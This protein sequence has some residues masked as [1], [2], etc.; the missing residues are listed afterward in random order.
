MSVT[1]AIDHKYSRREQS[2]PLTCR[3]VAQWMVEENIA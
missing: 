3:F 2:R 1:A